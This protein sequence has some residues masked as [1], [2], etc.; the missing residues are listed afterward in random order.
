MENGNNNFLLND[1]TLGSRPY[2]APFITDGDE[3]PPQLTTIYL[4]S[5]H[6]KDLDVTDLAY[7][8]REP[9]AHDDIGLQIRCL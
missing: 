6:V 2:Q 7:K 1:R 9:P 8:A 3:N 4:F 5:Y